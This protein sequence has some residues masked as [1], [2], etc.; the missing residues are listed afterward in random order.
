[1]ADAI[2]RIKT[3]M[4]V[5]D[6]VSNVGTI[7]KSLS[8]LKLPD[9]LKDNLS[10]NIGAF[11]KEYD[12]YQKKIA[13]GIKTQG[14]YNQIEKSLNRLRVLYTDIG[15]DA[16][17]AIKID[18]NALFDLNESKFKGIV[19]KIEQTIKQLSNIKVDTKAFTGP[20]EEIEKLTKN[21][22]IVGDEGILTRMMGN[23]ETGNISQAKKE[24]ASLIQEVEKAAPKFDEMGNRINKPGTFNVTHYEQ[25]RTALAKMGTALLEAG[26][27]AKPLE[28]ELNRL[29]Q[30]LTETVSAA[31]KDLIGNVGDY[32]KQ[33]AGVEKV[34]DS[35]KRM[36]EEEYNFNRQA[37]DIDRQIQSY[38]GLSQMIRKV[39]EI[40]RDAFQTV[41]ELD[42][43][44][45]E[46]AVVTNF[47]VGD[48]WD[49]L[50][51][52]TA[53]ANQLGATIKD[54]Y[55]AATLYF[56]QGLNLSQSMGLANETLK[57]ARIGGLQAAEAT[58]MM[59]AALRGFNMEINQLSAK[60][61][62][63]V[64]SELAAITAA[65]TKEIGSAMERTASIANSANMEFETTS[66]FLAQM[67]ETTREAPEN[68]GTAM[69]TIIARFQEMKQDPTKLVDSEGVALDANKIDTALKTIG[70]D[71]KNQKGEF[72]DL[73]DVFLDISERWDSLTQGQQRYIATIAAGSRQQSRFIAM[74]QNYERVKE[75]VDAANNSA[76]AGQK[77][78]E[79][80][81]EGLSA[82]LNK[83]KNAWDQFTMGLMNSQLIKGGIDALTGFFTIVNK[84]FDL[85]TKPFPDPF[86]GLIKSALTLTST[87]AMLNLGK[88]GA[89]G[90]VMA[91]VGWWKGE[92]KITDNFKAGW[93]VGTK[94]QKEKNIP[95]ANQIYQQQLDKRLTELGKQQKKKVVNVPIS[96]NPQI[97]KDYLAKIEA[98]GLSEE[99]KQKIREELKGPITAETQVNVNTIIADNTESIADRKDL[100]L[101]SDMLEGGEQIDRLGGKFGE[102]TTKVNNAGAALQQFGMTIGGPIGSALSTVGTLMMTLGSAL[103]AVAVSFTKNITAELADATGKTVDAVATEGLSKA[104]IKAAIT[105]GALGK[106]LWASLGPLALIA[107]AIGAVIVAYKLLDAAIVTNKEELEATTDAAAAA[108]EAFDL[109]KQETSELTDA[110][111]RIQESDKAFDNLVAGTAEFNEQLVT[112]N[113]QI[114]ELAQKYPMLNDYITTDKNGLMHISDEGLKAVKEYQKQIQARASAINII[115]AA[116]LAALENQQKAEKLRSTWGKDEDEQKKDQENADLLDQ[117]AEAEKKAAQLNAIRT[118]L[119]AKEIS[120]VEA[121]SAVYANLYEEKRKAAEVNINSMSKDD[122]RKAYAEYHGY[123]Y[124]SS[125]EKIKDNEGNEVD[126]DDAV[127]KDEVIEQTVLLNFEENASTLDV[128]LNDLDRK[129]K[130]SFSASFDGADHVISDLL[131][132]N[133]ETN[134]D[135]LKEVLS[136]DSTALQNLVDDLSKEEVAAI[137]GIATDQVTDAD[138]DKVEELF[139]ERATQIA[140]AQFESY[141]NLAS[142][143]AQAS[144]L[145]MAAVNTNTIQNSIREQIANLST[146]Q[147]TTLSTIGQTLDQKVGSEAMAAFID[148]ASDIYLSKDQELIDDFDQLIGEI[149]WESAASRLEGYNKAIKS[150]NE[151]I[152]EWGE[153]MR[154]SA[155]EVNIVGEAFDEFVSGDWEKLSE[156]ADNFTNA[157]GEIDATGIIAAAEESKSLKSLLD[158]GEVSAHGVAIALQGIEEGKYSVGA[159]NS[160]VL[161]L[162]SS[163]NRLEET[164]IEA[165]KIIEDFDPGID[166]GEG[167]DFM[168]EN[169]EKVKEYM[170]N[171]EWGNQQLQN[172]IK[173]ATGNDLWNET[174]RKNDGNLRK[175]TEELSKY[176]TAF[177][178]GTAEVWDKL[179]QRNGLNGKSIEENLK[180]ADIEGPLKEKFSKIQAY[181]DEEGNL[182][183]KGIEDL[184]TDEFEQ[185]LKEALVVSDEYAKLMAAN[186]MNYS[187]TEAETFKANDLKATIET[188]EFQ[189][190]IARDEQG[191]GILTDANWQ[192]LKDNLD[193]ADLERLAK[194]LGYVREEGKSAADVLEDNLFHTLKDGKEITDGLELAR[195]YAETYH[196]DETGGNRSARSLANVKEFQDEQG[197]LDIAKLSSGFEKVMSKTQADIASWETYRKVDEKGGTMSYNGQELK[198]DIQTEEEYR[199]EIEGLQDK[200]Q[201]YEVGQS[202]AEGI[203]NYINGKDTSAD[204]S[205]TTPSWQQDKKETTSTSTKDTNSDLRGAKDEMRALRTETSTKL[206]NVETNTA[207]T[208]DYVGGLNNQNKG[209]SNTIV[210]MFKKYH[211][212]L[213]KGYEEGKKENEEKSA[214]LL[215]ESSDSLENASS[216]LDSGADSFANLFSNGNKNTVAPTTGGLTNYVN[217]G[218]YASS[219]K[220]SK[221]TTQKNTSELSVNYTATIANATELQES[222]QKQLKTIFDAVAKQNQTLNVNATTKTTSKTSTKNTKGNKSQAKATAG[223]Q[224]MKVT[225]DVSAAQ[226]RIN[227]LISKF[228]KTQT[229]KYKVN[230]PKTIKVPITADFK[231]SWEKKV[232]ITKSGAKGINNNLPYNTLPTLGSLAKGTRY[233]RLGPRGKGG[234][235][236][237]G[238]KGYEIAWLPSESR[239]MILGTKG[240]QMISLPKDA[241][242]YNHEQSEDILRKKQTIDAGSHSGIHKPTTTTG[243]TVHPGKKGSGSSGSSGNKK[244][245]KKET[246]NNWSIEEVVRFNID[247]E[248]AEVTDEIARRT[249]EIEKTLVKISARYSDI[250]DSTKDQI[251]ALKA[252]Q[253]Y[254]QGLVDSYQRQ[255]DDYYERQAIVSWT[256]NKGKSKSKKI[257]IK[258]YLNQD[259]SINYDAIEKISTRAQREAVFK[260]VN[261]VKELYD[262]M[263]NA[264]KAIEDAADQIADLGKKVSEAYYQWDNELTE[265]YDLTQRINNEVSLTN[266][267]TSQIELELAKLNAGFG[268]TAQ[269]IENSRKVL[270]RN[271]NVIQ[272]QIKNQQQMVYARQRELQAA[273]STADELNNLIRFTNATDMDEATQQASM[274]WA[275]NQ[276]MG[277]ELG[278]KYVTNLFKD[279]DGSIQYEIDWE[280]FNTDNLEDAYSKETYEAIKKYLD[281]LNDKAT[282]FNNAIKEQT[283]YIKE[284]YEALHEYQEFIA[285]MEDTLIKGVEEEIEK[286]SENAKKISESITNALKDLLDEVKR[287]LDERR[288]QE[289]N[290]K[291][292]RD[293]AQKQQRLAALRA[294]TAGG[295]QVEIAQLEREIADAQQ[296][297]ERTLED[298][299]LERLQQQADEASRQ[300][301]RQIELAETANSIASETNKELVNM[302]LQ[303]PERYKEEIR[304]AWLEAQGYDDRGEAGQ[305]L[306]DQQFES[307]FTKLVTAIEQSGFNND[308]IFSAALDAQGQ[309]KEDTGTLVNLLAQ[310]NAGLIGRYDEL[311]ENFGFNAENDATL[312]NTESNPESVTNDRL[313]I[314]DLHQAGVSADAARTLGYTLEQLIGDNPSSPIYSAEELREGGYTAT[315][316]Y[317]AGL[318][319]AEQL[320][321]GGYTAQE[322]F[323]TNL[324]NLSDLLDLYS[325]A[326][327]KAAG[328]KAVDFEGSGVDYNRVRENFTIPELTEEN[329]YTEGVGIEQAYKQFL[330]DRGTKKKKNSKDKANWGKLSKSAYLAQV[331]R[332]EFLGKTEYEVA[333]ELAGT[334]KLDWNKVLKAAKGAG[335]KGKDVKAWNPK[336][337]SK[338]G[339]RKAFEKVFGK[340]KKFA[341]GGIVDFTGPAWLD[342]STSK[343][344]LVLNAQ[345]TKNFLALRD[346]LGKAINSTSG[347]KENDNA[348]YE[349]N[350]N[351]DHIANDYDV[352]R[353]AERIKKDII[354]SAGYRNVTQVRNFK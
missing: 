294:D 130:D 91:G 220:T 44:M 338:T 264:Q 131:G 277:A 53:N 124:N 26:K 122:I 241:V 123:K 333:K 95:N 221:D 183:F 167:E 224:V 254:N 16:A 114:T 88:K 345:D 132:S 291:T 18:P 328:F 125:T 229:L 240:P 82:K 169:A 329:A 184:T 208:Y 343:P 212:W 55:E 266:R 253:E 273:L 15:K 313:P 336:A 314:E 109:A 218:G 299:L 222:L 207:K 233:G 319:N 323:D 325:D 194:S 327:L 332:G 152:K 149:N 252:V 269:V 28:E 156:N 280:Q 71:L 116:D 268:T 346:V 6:V 185:F 181:W 246:I 348:F 195:S 57:M 161:Q 60:R 178:D 193:S 160:L 307:E 96:I 179:V 133:I 292:E 318:N 340:W 287:K 106:A 247:L 11:Y 159:V 250:V 278:R 298:Q 141:A 38:F 97:Q 68:L 295:H 37:Q 98:S 190:Q 115:Q 216:N 242:V 243:I 171:Q 306:L 135:I 36:H 352:D 146:Q 302:W 77:Q 90:A 84:I 172:Y 211:Q 213:D 48:M 235:T 39:G 176:V 85:F 303:D 30:E 112:A 339:F 40:A 2:L 173:L 103:E 59:T 286:E 56:Q 202:I 163:L 5:N 157:M 136:G 35:L 3:V 94:G 263:R 223:S 196:T 188:A 65:D 305:Y 105:S 255:I 283:D 51:T 180:N 200:A 142:M 262:G 21:Q 344:E 86:G 182:Q 12:K 330:I 63:D 315:E 78:F 118:A 272:E 304:A 258:D 62:N 43:A 102:L 73:D 259:G 192:I 300:R 274:E 134:T 127:I 34:T 75:L 231:G 175:T 92:G 248:L 205:N 22:K 341:Q 310:L 147:A 228:K 317:N 186:L 66:A 281:T 227:N 312:H 70:V 217:K 249:K 244:K 354:K 153:S 237:T 139:T 189:N 191:R 76:G 10:K 137:L 284:T 219:T 214:A 121:V 279:I 166:F 111:S 238:E 100:L 282:E 293:I 117:Q 209:E 13:D 199:L 79:K 265:V 275:Q 174:L 236:L 210:D 25:L 158:S 144:D 337:G 31:S 17:K 83:L 140:E 143:M 49:M 334:S 230:G 165:H 309:I 154:N 4:D 64:Y 42:A 80:T 351:V 261:S 119:T 289:D 69:K 342:G 32:N 260:E 201:W 150:N 311:G 267:F 331:A 239:S 72:R 168:K 326:E 120:D 321:K 9:N 67:I 110:I 74:M 101:T 347:Q 58:N 353:M 324:F 145:G 232:K 89:R 320:K 187:E 8:K 138:F 257:N 162:L 270:A 290:A 316:L 113:Q 148:K 170:D 23:I 126:Y 14:D 19:D 104:Q 33:A 349:I 285:N 81:L 151:T 301:E 1:M 234:L 215:A 108:S 50:P 41:K 206:N 297:Y 29:Q 296:S 276:F 271:N 155:D 322:L 177:S 27:D 54:V 87:L 24:Y 107:A 46:T 52:Y 350:I 226:K 45:V 245:K 128:V 197:R 20:I 93:G 204:S 251:E 288:K 99:V 335:R 198:S 129:F 47:D 61:I 256:T 225:A 164:A 203:I 308:E 7:Q